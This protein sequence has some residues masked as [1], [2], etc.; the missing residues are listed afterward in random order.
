MV[1]VA[2]VDDRAA[3]AEALARLIGELPSTAL[4]DGRPSRPGSS[5]DIRTF[6][7]A[8]ELAQALS[9]GYDPDLAFIDIVLAEEDETGR[10]AASGQAA[11]TA[12]GAS[13]AAEGTDA[14]PEGPHAATGI[15]VVERLFG[16]G[17]RTQVVYVSGYDSFHTQV[18]RTHHAAYLEKPFNRADVAYALELALAALERSHEEPIAFRLKGA[19]RVVRPA[20]I[21]YLESNLHVVRVHTRRDTFEIYGKLADLVQQLPARFARCHQSFIVN[22]A[23]VASL[24]ATGIV[25]VTGERVPVSRR[26]R[27]GVRQ[28]LFAYLRACRR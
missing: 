19:D 3:D 20:E 7:S 17:A 24:D 21:L 9:A 5:F 13:G 22:L 23:A 15:D 25:L 6:T 8:D 18:Y 1:T 16:L 4:P 28:A 10:A 26:M 2:I 12:P 14:R 27:A 11:S